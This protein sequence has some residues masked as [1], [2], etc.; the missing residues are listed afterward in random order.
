MLAAD[1]TE[2]V[3]MEVAPIAVFVAVVAEKMRW[4]HR[5]PSFQLIQD[6]LDVQRAGFDAAAPVDLSNV[7]VGYP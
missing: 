2:A 5:I 4:S 1:T 3:Q 7:V 6:W